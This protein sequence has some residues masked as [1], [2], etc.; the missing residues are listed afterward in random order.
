VCFKQINDIQISLSLQFLMM[1]VTGD[2]GVL[3][4]AVTAEHWSAVL[5]AILSLSN[6]C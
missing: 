3:D 6:L 4:K 2:K 5:I 1:K